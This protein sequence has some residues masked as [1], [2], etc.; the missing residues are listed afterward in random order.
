MPQDRPIEFDE[1]DMVDIPDVCGAVWWGRLHRWAETIRDDGCGAC[2][3]HAVLFVS[4][5]H[6]LVNIKLMGE[7]DP[8]KKVFDPANFV[9]T[10][11]IYHQSVHAAGLECPNCDS[12]NVLAPVA[13]ELPH[14][15]VAETRGE[16]VG[17][18]I[19]TVVI[20][21]ANGT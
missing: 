12:A 8:S 16:R 1:N 10:A 14:S 6:D 21:P 17:T 3:E 9:K 13:Q 19:P 4:A 2:G 18:E 7:G 20:R 11:D 15:H 5:M